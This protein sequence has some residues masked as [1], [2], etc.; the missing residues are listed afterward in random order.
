MAVALVPPLF[1]LGWS[2]FALWLFGVPRTPLTAALGVLVAAVAV[3]FSVLLGERFAA[4][5]R[6]GVP[7]ERAITATLRETGGAVAISAG[8]TIAGFAVLGFASIPVIAEFGIA[9]AI[10]LALVLL[11]LIVIAPATWV[12][13]DRAPAGASATADG[14]G[15][16]RRSSTLAAD[17]R[18][19]L[20]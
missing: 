6:V 4:L 11:A 18:T 20:G 1:A 13:A 14:G 8:A 9:T 7:R 10:D 16:P 5:R 2:E 3:E 15:G 12:L 17:G 19:T